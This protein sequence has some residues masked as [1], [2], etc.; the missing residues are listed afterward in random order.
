MSTSA[1]RPPLASRAHPDPP[2]THESGDDAGSGPEDATSAD[3]RRA[4]QPCV[5]VVDDEPGNRGI[6]RDVLEADGYEVVEVSNGVD[7]LDRVSKGDVDVV[8]LDV[9][10]PGM[11]GIQVL[12]ALR[13]EGASASLP[14]LLV[15]AHHSREERLRGIE[16]GA[17]DF[18]K[19][20]VDLMDL[21][22]RVRNAADVKSLHDK[23]RSDYERLIAL[24]AHRDSLVHMIVH[25]LRSPLTSIR[26]NLQLVELDAGEVLSPE[27]QGMPFGCDRGDDRVH[28]HGDHDAGPEP[29]RVR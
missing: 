9:V 13:A 17:N 23:V 10:M 16:A 21:R 7:A 26:S 25:D 22:L 14:V 29:P 24:E 28:R 27:T 15:T 3:E 6:I 12:R 5:L 11:D 19:K 8:L 1:A 4:T 20:P 18:L 2:P